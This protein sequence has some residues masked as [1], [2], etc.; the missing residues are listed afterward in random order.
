MA[1]YTIYKNFTCNYPVFVQ[2]TTK[3]MIMVRVY[4]FWRNPIFHDS[5]RMLLK[6]PQVEWVGDSSDPT[7]FND[8]VI[9][10]QPD[11]VLIEQTEEKEYTEILELLR[12][13]S[14]CMKIIA[15]NLEDNQLQILKSDKKTIVQAE[16]FLDL[17]L[18]NS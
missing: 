12:A 17:V 5:V 11:I 9:Q 6:H 2:R 7:A 4:A 13:N 15:I 3:G 16:D 1:G 8:E 10:L 18:S 14:I